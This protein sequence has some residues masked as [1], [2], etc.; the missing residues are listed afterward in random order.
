MEPLPIVLEII[1][2]HSADPE[3]E[4]LIRLYACSESDKQI[5]NFISYKSLLHDLKPG[6]VVHM[7]PSPGGKIQI[8]SM[9]EEAITISF[10][11]VAK[12]LRLGEEWTSGPIK[13]FNPVD[14][15]DECMITIRYHRLTFWEYIKL[16]MN[17]ILYIHEHSRH[18]LNTITTEP[19]EKV[20]SLINQA[21]D[22]G[23]PVLY[24]LKALLMASNN[25]HSAKILRPG[26][27]QDILLEGIE[28]GALAPDDAQ[29]WEWLKVA[30]ES[31]DPSEF[32]PDM[33]RYYDL[34]ASAA[35]EGDTNA[36]D[37]MNE[38][39]PPEQIIEE[40]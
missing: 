3:L 15:S 29:G 37:I 1:E 14:S 18:P 31:N 8:E 7:S 11:N 23:N 27:F 22:D 30:A 40:D 39:W 19:E 25:W 10:F 13:T 9:S 17:R 36:L 2:T 33:E 28:K 38:V 24:P 20:L 21:I 12:I 35:E 32:M 26:L 6:Q 4:D 5:I 16:M 34:L